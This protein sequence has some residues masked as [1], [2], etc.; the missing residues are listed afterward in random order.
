MTVPVDRRRFLAGLAALSVPGAARAA[1]RPASGFWYT[2]GLG[3]RGVGLEMDASGRR[4][5][6]G[7]Y[8]YDADGHDVWYVGTCAYDGTTCDGTLAQY[9]GGTPFAGLGLQARPPD[10]VGNVATVS[11]RFAG[12]SVAVA[13]IRLADGSTA[14]Y[15]LARCPLDGNAV[16]PAPDW[17]PQTGWWYSPDYPGTGFFLESQGEVVIGGEVHTR[18]FLV[19]MTYG[20]AGQAIWY[21]TGGLYA[22]VAT[23]GG[24]LPSLAGMLYEYTGG[25]TLAGS[26]SAGTSGRLRIL[27]ERG[28]IRAQFTTTGEGVLDLPAGRR[29]AI[30]RFAF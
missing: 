22:R 15:D 20:D 3:G 19:G 1:I 29:L 2:T 4:A 8:T 17:A 6:L 21:A 24:L 16:T 5:Y 10:I 26:I 27:G 25:A 13:S 12:D 14:R 18:F 30:R 28:S 9:A 11:L 7:W 23:A